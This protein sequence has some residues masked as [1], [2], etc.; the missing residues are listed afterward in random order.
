MRSHLRCPIRSALQRS[1]WHRSF[2]LPTFAGGV[3]SKTLSPTAECLIE[4]SMSRISPQSSVLG[5]GSRVQCPQ[6]CVLG[7]GSL[8]LGEFLQRICQPSPWGEISE[9]IWH[10]RTRVFHLLVQGRVWSLWTFGDLS[11][12]AY[13]EIQINLLLILSCRY[14]SSDVFNQLLVDGRH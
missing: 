13:F 6:S 9:R 4:R 7:P 5:P 3:S 12:I 11:L 1:T 2:G 14:F 8:V 10:S